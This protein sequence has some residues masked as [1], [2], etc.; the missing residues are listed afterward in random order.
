MSVGSANLVWVLFH[1]SHTLRPGA[2]ANVLFVVTT[3]V[4]ESKWKHSLLSTRLGLAY[5]HLY[6][7]LLGKTS[8]VTEPRIKAWEIDSPF[9]GR[10][11]KVTKRRYEK[12]V[13]NQAH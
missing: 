13:K 9:G 3:S 4:Q 12:R 11:C 8:H 1:V 6:V 7:I 10:G 2:M 5:C